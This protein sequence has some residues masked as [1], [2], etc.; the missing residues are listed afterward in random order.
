MHTCLPGASAVPSPSGPPPSRRKLEDVE[1]DP[2][3]YL[4]AHGKDKLDDVLSEV[5]KNAVTGLQGDR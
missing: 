3:G 4:T 5:A 2:M 1:F